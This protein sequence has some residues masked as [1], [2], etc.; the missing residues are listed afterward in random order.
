MRASLSNYQNVRISD[1]QAEVDVD[2]VGQTPP[3]SQS[4]KRER[5]ISLCAGRP[6]RRSEAGR[7]NRPAPFEMTAGGTGKNLN[8]T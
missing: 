4:I 1:I 7:K 6:L 8:S 2:G 3:Y 5:E